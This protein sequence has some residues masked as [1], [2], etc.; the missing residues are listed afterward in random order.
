M[1]NVEDAFSVSIKGVRGAK[2]VLLIDDVITTGATLEAAAWS[3]TGTNEL[4]VSILGIGLA[5]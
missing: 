3:F 5:I 4:Q 2:H 1:L